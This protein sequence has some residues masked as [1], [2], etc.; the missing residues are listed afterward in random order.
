MK[1]KKIVRAINRLTNSIE[2]LTEAV[3]ESSSEISDA[4][5]EVSEWGKAIDGELGRIALEMQR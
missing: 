4:V 1:T 3:R 5:E 2:T